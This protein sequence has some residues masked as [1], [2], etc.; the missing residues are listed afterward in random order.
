M[1]LVMATRDKSKIIEQIETELLT[2]NMDYSGATGKAG[3]HKF[4]DREYDF[5]LLEFGFVQVVEDG[6][7]Q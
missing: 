6:E 5:D 1:K 2:K 4:R 3:V 7:V